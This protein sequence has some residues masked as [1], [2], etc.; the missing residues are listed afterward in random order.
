MEEKEVIEVIEEKPKR[1][2][3][4]SNNLE[5]L[6]KMREIRAEKLKQKRA[7]KEEIQMKLKEIE[8]IKKEKIDKEYQEALKLKESIDVKKKQ[9]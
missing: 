2:K 8:K 7:E 3:G 1:K 9:T 4:G 6:A 5:H